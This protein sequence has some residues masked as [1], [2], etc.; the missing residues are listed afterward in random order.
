M[1]VGV[2][3]AR[4]QRSAAAVDSLAAD[5]DV[6]ERASRSDHLAVIADKQ[7]REALQSPI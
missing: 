5:A 4:K 2:D 7:A 6:V 1:T 3:Q